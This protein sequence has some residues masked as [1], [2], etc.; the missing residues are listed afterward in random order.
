MPIGSTQLDETLVNEPLPRVAAYPDQFV[1]LVA[2]FLAPGW[3]VCGP[4]R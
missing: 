4:I 3:V 2:A 1:L